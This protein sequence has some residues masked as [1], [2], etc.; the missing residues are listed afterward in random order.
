MRSCVAALHDEL[1]AHE[2]EL[3]IAVSIAMQEAADE[4]NAALINAVGDQKKCR[5]EAER[6]TSFDESCNGQE[7]R[8][9]S[10]K[11]MWPKRRLMTL[12]PTLESNGTAEIG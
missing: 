5:H 12:R 3:A 11:P 6:S 9:R 2:V 10:R 4:H 7:T 1:D 8:W